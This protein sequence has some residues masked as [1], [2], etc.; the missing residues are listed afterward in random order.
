V[1]AGKVEITRVSP[2]DEAG[3]ADAVA[4]MTAAMKTDCP[5]LKLPTVTGYANMLRYGWDLNPPWA[6]LARDADGTA[7]GL[8]TLDLPK[9][10]NLD[11][12]WIEFST[13]PDHRGRGVSAAMLDFA[14]RT[15]AELGR[16]SLG[17][18][19]L[20]VPGIDAFARARGFELRS[21]DINRRQELAGL[22]YDLVQ[23]LYDEATKAATGYELLRLTGPLPEEML[24]GMVKLTASINDAPTD[25]LDT[26]DDVFSPERMRDYEEAQRNCGHR[27]YRVIARQK[28]TG[29]L[30]GH[31]IV[32]VETERPR[33][34]EQHDT[35]VDSAHRGHR[36]GALVKSAMLLWLRDEEPALAEIDTWNA[37]SNRHMIGINEQLNYRVIARNLSYQRPR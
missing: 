26:E 12:V 19:A 25:D 17:L 3:C 27:L 28:T 24:D 23:R 29:E 7:V 31:T 10:E 20:D 5:D 6:Y 16:G 9:H 13:H 4:V 15:S 37:E 11:Q 21:A 18:G 2:D 33:L 8:L 1:D 30:A 34:G 36:L 32:A 35:A 14:E 22:D